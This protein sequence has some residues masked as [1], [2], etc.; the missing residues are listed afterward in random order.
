M[1]KSTQ[2]DQNP[3]NNNDAENKVKDEQKGLE[4]LHFVDAVHE[5]KQ[6]TYVIY[7]FA[8]PFNYWNDFKVH[9]SE[10]EAYI[11]RKKHQNLKAE[12]L[13]FVQSCFS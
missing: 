12:S 7:S 8:Y 3:N 5:E 13:L 6:S 10:E 1:T 9:A 11:I 4:D 2:R